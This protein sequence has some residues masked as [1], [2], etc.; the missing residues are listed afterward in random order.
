MSCPLLEQISVNLV[1]AF[2]H[3]SNSIFSMYTQQY[4]ILYITN[5][6]TLNDFLSVLFKLT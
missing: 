6:T 5:K 3:Y 4:L 1:V 2:V